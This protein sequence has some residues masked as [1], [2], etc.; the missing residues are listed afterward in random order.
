MRTRT[1]KEV[2]RR[3]P[4]IQKDKPKLSLYV[5]NAMEDAVIHGVEEDLESLIRTER[6]SRPIHAKSENMEDSRRLPLAATRKKQNWP[7]VKRVLET[8][9]T[10]RVEKKDRGGG[11]V[12]KT[13][14]EDGRTTIR[15]RPVAPYHAYHMYAKS[16]WVAETPQKKR[17]TC[18]TKIGE[19]H[20]DPTRKM[21]L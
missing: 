21:S 16:S 2:I 1:E 18:N 15:N 9:V 19:K 12:S 11:R 8:I 3:N 6:R 4:G 14:N 5:R 7:K 13:S 20:A 17:L 10:G